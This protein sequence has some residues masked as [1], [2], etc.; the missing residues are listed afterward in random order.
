MMNTAG[1]QARIFNTLV[2]SVISAQGLIMKVLNQPTIRK[3][4]V[5]FSVVL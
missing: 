5:I 2:T 1:K 4:G 3:N